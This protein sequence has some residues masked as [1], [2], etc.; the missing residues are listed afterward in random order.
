MFIENTQRIVGGIWLILR[1]R[2]FKFYINFT[3]T[4]F[5]LQNCHYFKVAIPN[6]P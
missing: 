5:Y 1:G 6:L 3:T 4:L 2:K